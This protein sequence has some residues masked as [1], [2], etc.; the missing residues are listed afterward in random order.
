[1]KQETRRTKE[2]FDLYWQKE[3]LRRRDD[4]RH[5][6]RLPKEEAF[7]RINGL[8]GK[9]FSHQPPIRIL[10]IGPG[11]G[12]DT[13]CLTRVGDQVFAIDISR[14]SLIR[15]RPETSSGSEFTLKQAMSWRQA[16]VQG[17]NNH[18]ALPI[19]VQMDGSQLGFKEGTFDL[20][21]G[22]TVLMHLH[23]RSFFPETH[24]ILKKGG[25]AIFIEPLKYNPFLFFY[26]ILLSKCR[27]IHPQYLSPHEIRRLSSYFQ[28]VEAR[29]FY[30]FVILF[31]PILHLTQM[32][33]DGLR[34]LVHSIFRLLERFDQ[35]LLHLF[36]FLRRFCSFVVIECMK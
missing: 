32:K 18:S 9:G 6:A 24:R 15:V 20:L 30:L 22:N 33:N 12:Q 23:R 25:T 14:E 27:Q 11:M 16:R 31:F 3:E 35:S 29:E 17:R 4:L 19:V 36:P 34:A 13:H 5:L 21:F 28:E 2:F 26:R 10:E 7:K 8:K 1:M